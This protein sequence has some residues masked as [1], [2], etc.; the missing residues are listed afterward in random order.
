MTE[1]D[2]VLDCYNNLKQLSEYKDIILEVPYLS[3]SID[4]IIVDRQ[5]NIIS[6]EFKLS[7]WKRAIQQAKDHSMG[8]DMAYICMPEP[9]QGFKKNFIDKLKLN[10][11]GLYVYDNDSRDNICPLRELI[12][13][14]PSNSKWRPHV[15]SLKNIIEKISNKRI[16]Y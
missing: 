1:A 12:Q 15:D 9:A 11:I 7:D 2:M 6:V 13:P 14:K 16:F 10:G 8:S 3:R 4:M 5:D